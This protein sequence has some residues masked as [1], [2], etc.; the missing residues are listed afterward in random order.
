MTQEQP[1]PMVVIVSAALSLSACSPFVR[2]NADGTFNPQTFEIDEGDTVLW[3]GDGFLFSTTDAIA[4]IGPPDVSHTQDQICGTVAGGPTEAETGIVGADFSGPKRKGISGIHALGPQGYG[5]IET[6]H[7]DQA[8]D[9]NTVLDPRNLRDVDYITERRE[10]VPPTNYLLCTKRVRDGKGNWVPAADPDQGGISQVLQSTWDNP[11]I[12]GVVLR[13]RWKDLQYDDG[14]TIV[15]DWAPID[16]EFREALKRGK[17][18]SINIH[19]GE[20]T[21]TFIFTDYDRDPDT[22]GLQQPPE[23]NVVPVELKDY[24]SDDDTPDK[25][26]PELTLGSP[27]DPNY[28]AKIE[29]LYDALA[30]H[31]KS[32]ARFFQAL[33]Y[34][35]VTGMNLTTGEAR[36]PKRCL[37]P[38]ASGVAGACWCNTAIWA[39]AK[40]GYTP[41]ALYSYYN[42]IENRILT[43]FNGAKSLHYMLIQD[44]FPRVLGPNDYFRDEGHDGDDEKQGT[45]DDVGPDGIDGTADDGHVGSGFPG[46]FTQTVQVL[47]FG[48][49]GRFA[50]PGDPTALSDDTET[51]KLFV[52][53][54]SGLQEHPIDQ[55]PMATEC[56][57]TADHPQL[58]D[59]SG[60]QYYGHY[61]GGIPTMGISGVGTGCPN[62]WAA[63]DGYLG[64]LIGYQTVNGVDLP[65]EIDSSLWNMTAGSNAAY[66]ELYEE[67]AWVIGRTLSTGPAAAILDAKGYFPQNGVA[68][69]KNLYQWGQ[70][71]HQR[72]EAI[73]NEQASHP[74]MADPFPLGHSFAFTEPLAPG[75]VREYWYINPGRCSTSA[76]ATPYGSIR[77]LGR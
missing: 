9:C 8:A 36:L 64:Q 28:L 53:Q 31:L 72:R 1:F 35:K 34:V 49:L 39:G 48:R 40:H 67:A 68:W 61:S 6:S 23:S 56:L 66:Y 59:A 13:V 41:S 33:G 51:G 54:H 15:T 74:N 14:S 7:T 22:R 47:E 65:A 69:Q 46:A 37:D 76:S 42:N 10:W 27:A 73:A 18:V 62:Q 26:G 29:G 32:D 57:Q 55:D 3:L 4:R 71:L 45:P 21:P 70:Q 58:V 19:A 44:G 16:R 63:E 75:E 17:M 20:D 5:F 50:L 11:D 30:T 2:I 60:K 24:G 38:D 12:D 25:C 43:A 77:V 52:S